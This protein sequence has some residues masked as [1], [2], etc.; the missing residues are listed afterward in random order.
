MCILLASDV[1][2]NQRIK[3]AGYTA[4]AAAFY[5]RIGVLFGMAEAR[6]WYH[7]LSGAQQ[8]PRAVLERLIGTGLRWLY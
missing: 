7:V 3:P 4:T 1:V 6:A 5:L 2:A 8:R